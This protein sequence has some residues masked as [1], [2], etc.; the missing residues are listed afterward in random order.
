MSS[1]SRLPEKVHAALSGNRANHPHP[2]FILDNVLD[3]EEYGKLLEGF[4]DH[5]VG[6][7]GHHK[8]VNYTIRPNAQ[9]SEQ[10]SA[11]WQNFIATIRS[12]E[13]V[14]R[15]VKAC[16]AETL[17][18]YPGWWRWLLYFRLKDVKNYEI[19]LAFSAN[20]AGRY[21]PP[22]TDNS[23][24]V[25][26][27]VLYFADP[28]YSGASE[29]TRFFRPKSQTVL[30]EAVKR[31]NRLS[32]SRI[33]RLTPLQLQPMTSC[34]IHDGSL[35]TEQGR[36]AEKWFYDNFENDFNVSFHPNRIAGFVKTQ[37]SF[38]SVDMR[39]SSFAGPRRSLLI[40]LNLKHSLAARAWQSFR[41]RVLGLSS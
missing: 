23:Y 21:L 20:Y 11:E 29:G 1:I 19:N 39:T 5:L 3:E 22:H 31:F 9:V 10:I 25:L 7:L 33:T 8:F 18:R 6:N 27:L 32:D 17:R 2:R 4:P 34:S 26:A 12:E 41:T 36:S 30:R 13:F 38:H 28:D 37:N 40:N 24:K 15:L 14:S 16:L 35:K